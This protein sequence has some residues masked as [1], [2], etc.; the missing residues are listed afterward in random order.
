MEANMIHDKSDTTQTLP[1][2]LVIVTLLIWSTFQT[3]QLYNER[4][5]LKTAH[6]NQE[7][8][9]T[10]AGKMRAQLDVIAAGAQRLADQGNANAQT[11]VR[12]LAKSGISINPK[13]PAA[14][15]S[16]PK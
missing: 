16:A 12:Q 5:N 14:S 4:Q 1:L 8:V 7:Q 10:D 15:A 6:D 2:L 11:I 9:I 13:Q 3:V